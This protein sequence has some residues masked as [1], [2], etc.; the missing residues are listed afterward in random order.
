MVK[1]GAEA[2]AIQ[3]ADEDMLDVF[4]RHCLRIALGTPL[5]DRISNNRLYKKCG[6]ILFSKAIMKE[7][8][9][10]LGHVVRMTD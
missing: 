2:W 1:Y 4:Q 10:S 6:S 8:L 5:T 3:E 7:R 9:R